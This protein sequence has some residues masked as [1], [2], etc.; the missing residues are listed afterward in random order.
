MPCV[1]RWVSQDACWMRPFCSR[2]SRDVE[3][4]EV[5]AK[6]KWDRAFWHIW[7]SLWPD[8]RPLGRAGARGRD[9]RCFIATGGTLFSNVHAWPQGPA[10]TKARHPHLKWWSKTLGANTTRSEGTFEDHCVCKGLFWSE[11]WDFRS[12][13]PLHN[14]TPTD[15]RNKTL[16]SIAMLDH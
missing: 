16:V 13:Q 7:V 8:S 1:Q 11:A 3:L 14:L 4:D 12:H 15:V 10:W 6:W 9:R 5:C 2:P